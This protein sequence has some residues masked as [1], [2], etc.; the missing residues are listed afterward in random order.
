MILTGEELA[1]MCEPIWGS[2]WKTVLGRRLACSRQ[3]IHTKSKS[4]TGLPKSFKRALLTAIE[5]QLLVV[6]KSADTLRQDVHA[7]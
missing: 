4:K 3:T 1:K 5:E 2:D 7:P 6:A